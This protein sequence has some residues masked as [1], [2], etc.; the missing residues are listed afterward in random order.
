MTIE[1]DNRDT[2]TVYHLRLPIEIDGRVTSPNGAREKEWSQALEE[3]SPRGGIAPALIL[4]VDEK[5]AVAFTRANGRISLAWPA[6]SWARAPLPDGSVGPPLQRAGDVLAQHDVVYVVQEVSGN[7]RMVQTPD[8]QGALVAV[9]PKDGAISALTGGFDYFASNYNRAV[10][11]KRQPGSA[12][13]PFLYSAALEQGADV[14][15]G[16]Y[17]AAAARGGERGVAVAGR[18]I[19][20]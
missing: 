11:A 18:H 6:I 1:W 16:Q 13:K 20:H 3:F 19:E 12:F 8:V 14:V 2:G 10:Q 17:I 7:W 9:D 4:S 5:S 15:G